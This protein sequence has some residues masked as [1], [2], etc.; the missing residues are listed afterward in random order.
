M[1]SYPRSTNPT[2]VP[3]EGSRDKAIAVARDRIDGWL[4]S[5]R[6]A[7]RI[8]LDSAAAAQCLGCAL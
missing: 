3:F 5:P 1:I 6:H 2:P 8:R 7:A 4:N